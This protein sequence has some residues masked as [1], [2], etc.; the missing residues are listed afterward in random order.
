MGHLFM[1]YPWDLPESRDPRAYIFP[2]ARSRWDATTVLPRE[3]IASFDNPHLRQASALVLQQ[4]DPW[5]AK[6]SRP[7][8]PDVV[9]MCCYMGNDSFLDNTSQALPSPAHRVEAV[10]GS[11]PTDDS[12]QPA[13]RCRRG[14]PVTNWTQWYWSRQADRNKLSCIGLI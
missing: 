5:R 1:A 2:E 7:D 4:D 9:L 8:L 3:D 10:G 11:A 13:M 6:V 14:F 12:I